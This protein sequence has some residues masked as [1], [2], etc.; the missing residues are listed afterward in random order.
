MLFTACPSYEEEY[1]VFINNTDDDIL[2]AM[3][4]DKDFSEYEYNIWTT[5]MAGV[6]KHTMEEVKNSQDFIRAG[7]TCYY[8]IHVDSYKSILEKGVAKFQFFNY[9]SICNIPWQRVC[10]ERILLKEVVFESWEE[11]EDCKFTIKVQ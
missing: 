11:L 1:L 2:W 3:G 8:T 6:V 10:D 9:D 4:F 5:T 7:D